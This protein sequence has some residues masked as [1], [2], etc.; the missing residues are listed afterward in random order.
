VRE[1]PTPVQRS[2][3][4]AIGQAAGIGF[5]IAAALILPI[6]GGLVLDGRLGRA[7]LFTLIGVAV[8]LV[9]A[10]YQLVELTKAANRVPVDP[11]AVEAARRRRADEAEA[12]RR[13][14]AQVE[15]RAQADLDAGNRG[16]ERAP[17]RDEE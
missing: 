1:R 5:G 7:P 13:F 17:R 12:Q 2:R 3:W 10:G 16:P 15:A 9:A 6:V 11:V 4:Q 8:G 14:L